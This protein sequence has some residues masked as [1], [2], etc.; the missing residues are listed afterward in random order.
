MRTVFEDAAVLVVEKPAGRDSTELPGQVL[1]VHRLDK[2]TSGLLVYARTS[3][4]ARRLARQFA[5]HSVERAY[6]CIA[7]GDVVAG[8]IRS[9]LVRNRGDGLR[10]SG[11]GG[12]LAVTH[13]E[14][15]RHDGDRTRCRVT[16]TTGRTHQIRIHLAE[17]GH[18]I[19]GETVYVRDFRAAGNTLLPSS[20]LMLH[21]T[22]L[23]FTHPVTHAVIRFHSPAPF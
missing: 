18:P 15:L 12:K 6:E 4:V 20:R 19:V 22:D 21:A 9:T 17:S 2:L 1:V 3:G 11:E 14:V 16:L 7:H 10:G 13:V 23:G 5:A 8:E